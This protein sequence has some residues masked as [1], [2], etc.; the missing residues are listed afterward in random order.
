M[1]TASSITD[2]NLPASL[3][4]LILFS[5]LYDCVCRIDAFGNLQ[6]IISF[7]D[8]SV[9]RSCVGQ[10]ERPPLTFGRPRPIP[11]GVRHRLVLHLSCRMSVRH[12]VRYFQGSK[13]LIQI[14]AV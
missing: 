1:E 14:N 4:A 2:R 12:Y 10:C 11:T 13:F 9:T 6:P 3:L 8:Q 7:V 5:L